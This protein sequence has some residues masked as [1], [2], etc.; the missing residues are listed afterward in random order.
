MRKNNLKKKKSMWYLCLHAQYISMENIVKIR[1]FSAI[2]IHC[3]PSTSSS[4]GTVC[5][6]YIYWNFS[7]GRWKETLCHGNK[8]GGW[9]HDFWTGGTHQTTVEWWWNP[10]MFCKSI[11]VRAQWLGSLVS[12]G[13]EHLASNRQHRKPCNKNSSSHVE[14]SM[15]IAHQPE[16]GQD[17]LLIC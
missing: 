17:L 2:V 16:K 7:L 8:S 12:E 11:R 4:W 3:K 13:V 10:G 15:K 6:H 14:Q 5:L 9:W 1:N